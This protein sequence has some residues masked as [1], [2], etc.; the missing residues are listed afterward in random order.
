[1][2]ARDDKLLSRLLATFKIEA[3]E[4]IQAI[5]SGLLVLERAAPA[6]VRAE[7]LDA[8][9]RAA[10]S[11]KGAART[12]NV[13]DVE[14]L[15]QSLEGVFAALKREDLTMS[16]ELFDLLHRSVDVLTGLLQPA[17]TDQSSKCSSVAELLRSLQTV[18]SGQRLPQRAGPPNFT[19]RE[20]D[21]AAATAPSA[22]AGKRDSID[23]IRVATTKLDA[24]LRQAEELLAVKLATVQ[25]ASRL[26][27]CH[28]Q[29][30]E[31]KSK[32]ARLRPELRNVR[33]HGEV[34][35][36][37][38]GWA[39]VQEF[40]E[41][42]Q[43]FVESLEVELTDLLKCA[44]HDQRAT[45]L[46]V[47]GLLDDM[48]AVVMQPFSTL[49]D[50]LPRF[51][52]ELSR[53]QG[54]HV[55]LSVTGDDI[56]I[57]RRIL[58]EM[59]DPLIHLARNSL[60]HGIEAPAVREL[61]GKPRHGTITIGICTRDSGN[62]EFMF[63]DD[64]SGIDASSV[65]ASAVKGG[66][67][68]QEKVRALS[69][70]EAVYLA[71]QSGVSTSPIIT[72]LSGRGL[73]LAIVKEKIAKVGGSLRIE[74]RIGQGT[75]FRFL[76]P[77][78]LSRF[79]G[80]IVRAIEHQFVVPTST[81]QRVVRLGKGAIITVGSRETISLD[82]EAVSL[83]RLATVLDLPRSVAGRGEPT[84]TYAVVLASG[85]RRIAF[86]VDEVINEQEVLVKPLGK[87]L[88]RVRNVAGAT[89]LG[90]GKVVP[91]LNIADLIQSAVLAS[92]TGIPIPSAPAEAP[93]DRRKSVL[94][95]ED[96]ITSR[97][98]LRNIL[99]AAGYEVQT[100]VDGIDAF[101]KL[102][103][104]EFDLVVSD[105]EMPRLNGFDLTSKVRGERKLAD[106]PVVLVTALNSREDQERGIDVGANAYIAKGSFDQSNLLEVI[107]RLI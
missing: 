26:R 6:E 34:A 94:V 14:T 9:F 85:H 104:G 101:T 54:K 88:V 28:K 3:Q 22:P 62:V 35:Q 93:E 48:K 53:K 36:T 68:S 78:T 97:I 72:D 83:V 20:M 63:A 4:H 5:A 42:S 79:R 51:V 59:K 96:S 1:V 27:L 70:E 33:K 76:L 47:D 43:V 106:L 7:A 80:L 65:K 61:G 55:E 92:D 91:V 37:P 100:A 39:P 66:H 23:T 95:A 50:V 84:A 2:P 98:L 75:A 45:A 29:L 90:N 77:T 56:E 19:D 73:G 30:V 81:V 38:N 16:P 60:D 18:V 12:V 102:R 103:S 105:V 58:E 82:N 13:T 107:Q 21:A 67:L 41:S 49:L 89:V 57:D 99:E 71:L 69:D 15:C 87:Q 40:L 44:D 24:I 74:T 11:L 32:W 86:L 17:D 8:T 46:M 10:H 31:W 64:G 52:R 25:H